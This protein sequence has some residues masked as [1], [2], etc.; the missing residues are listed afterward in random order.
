[1]LKTT[2]SLEAQKFPYRKLISLT[3]PIALHKLINSS[4]PLVDSAMIS[5]LG[6]SALTALGACNQVFLIFFL[7]ITGI[8]D[9]TAL[10]SAQYLSLIHI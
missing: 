8:A 10:F 3:I 5:R 7:A 6:E 9:G 1:M 2:P 4:M